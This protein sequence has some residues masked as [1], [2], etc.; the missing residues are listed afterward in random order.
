MRGNSKLWRPSLERIAWIG[1]VIFLAY[2]IWPQ[3]AAAFGMGA[4]SASAPTFQLATLGGDSISSVG[5][6]GK[7]VLVNFW[8][9]WCPPCRVEMPGFQKVYERKRDEGFVILGIS[10]DAASDDVRSFLAERN[11]TYPVAMAAG[12]VTQRFGGANVLPTSFLIDRNGKIRHEVRGIF[13]SIALERAVDR[14]L[15]EPASGPPQ[16]TE[17]LSGR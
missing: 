4:S 17:A 2:R 8:A 15:A 12:N 7:V 11:I 9:T 14:L 13:S 1:L 10:T 5:L 3:V 16:T 6:R